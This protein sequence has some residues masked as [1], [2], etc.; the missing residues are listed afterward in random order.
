MAFVKLDRAL[1]SSSLW[2]AGDAETVR[3]WVYLLLAANEHGTVEETL[4]AIARGCKLTVRR[5]Q[6]ILD[7]FGAPDA[8]SRTP[9][10]E[11][12]RIRIERAPQW[13]IEILNYAVYRAKDHGAAAARAGIASACAPRHA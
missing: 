4:P 12:R 3:L 9:T 5:T 8:F 13:R 10:A 11:G 2:I 1:L 7:G 6:K